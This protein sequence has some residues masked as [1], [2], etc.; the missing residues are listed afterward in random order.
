MTP[1]EKADQ[2]IQ[3]CYDLNGE[4]KLTAVKICE[5]ILKL[6]CLKFGQHLEEFKDKN[7]YF[8]YWEEVQN[9]VEKI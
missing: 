1:K 5:E 6:E 4:W 3:E 2:L 8:S 7:E 9:E